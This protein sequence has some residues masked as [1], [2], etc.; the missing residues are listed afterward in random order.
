MKLESHDNLFSKSTPRCNK[1]FAV[2]ETLS[3]R[4]AVCQNFYDSLVV[5]KW[6]IEQEEYWLV[7]LDPQY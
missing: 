6:G 2:Q 7:I 5:I 3:N 4:G 1:L